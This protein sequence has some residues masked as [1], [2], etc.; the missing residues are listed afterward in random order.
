MASSFDCE[1]FRDFAANFPN[2]LKAGILYRGGSI[3][4]CSWESV[5]CPATVINLR[6]EEDEKRW[7]TENTTYIHC[8]IANK[9]EKY[10]TSQQQVKRWLTDI[11]HH[12]S[13]AKTPI[14]L[15]CKAGRDRTGIAIAVLLRILL[16]GE[17]DEEIANDYLTVEGAD[18]SLIELS[19][20]GLES[21]SAR[22][23]AASNQEW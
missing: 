16:G 10:E 8:P 21:D 3:G 11:M 19:L 15:H 20:R 23:S 18:R 22:K 13:S 2:I 1:N 9:I 4:Y 12:L 7:N 6:F 14:L 17:M 5:G